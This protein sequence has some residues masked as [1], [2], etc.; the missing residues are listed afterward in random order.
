MKILVTRPQPQADTTARKL[1]AMGHEVVLEPMLHFQPL[2]LD[3][4]VVGGAKA[5]AVTSAK[6]IEALAFNKLIEPLQ[7]L[8]LYSVGEATA[9][10]AKGAGFQNIM[11]AE[12]DVGSL[13][14]LI[15]EHSQQGPVFYPAAVD[16]SGDLSGQLAG[17]G[18]ACNMVEAYQ[19]SAAS[20]LSAQTH[21]LITAGEIDC[22]LFYSLRTIQVFLSLCNLEKTT[23]FLNSMK[24]LCV[25]NRVAEQTASFGEVF[26]AKTPSEDGL[27]ELL[28][29]ARSERT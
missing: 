10:A 26:V 7:L 5:I 27:F 25:S 16:R 4:D 3:E 2:S 29:P 20:Q 8:P 14:N 23:V 9:Q 19:M 22:T 13:A 18:V 1:V 21:R 15:G 17:L 28:A 11:C 12:G 24:A 6:A